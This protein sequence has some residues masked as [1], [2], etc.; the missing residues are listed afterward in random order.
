M[1]GRR[2]PSGAESGGADEFAVAAL[3]HLDALYGAAL[4]LTRQADQAQDLVQD[5]YLKAIRARSR[6]ERGTSLKAWLYTILNNTWRNRRRDGSRDRIDYDSAAVEEA[7][8]GGAGSWSQA[9]D[10]PEALLMRESL[11]PRAQSPEPRAKTYMLVSR[12]VGRE[13]LANVAAHL[14]NEAE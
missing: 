5:T 4:R 6:F 11:K 8:E 1:F 7:A 2:G 13:R 12:T 3:E 9:V 14:R 10:S